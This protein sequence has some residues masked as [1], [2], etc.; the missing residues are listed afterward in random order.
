[1]DMGAAAVAK[2]PGAECSAPRQNELGRD[3]YPEYRGVAGLP[4]DWVL[5]GCLRDSWHRYRMRRQ[6]V[7]QTVGSAARA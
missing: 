2:T 7:D 4:R 1:M 3:N 6:P 5:P